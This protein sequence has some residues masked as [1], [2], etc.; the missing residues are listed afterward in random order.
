[1]SSESLK[2][3]STDTYWLIDVKLGWDNN[4]GTNFTLIKVHWLRQKFSLGRT[5]TIY[6]I[7]ELPYTTEILNGSNLN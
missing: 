2:I 5:L 4:W 1:M 3:N 7:P 6:Q